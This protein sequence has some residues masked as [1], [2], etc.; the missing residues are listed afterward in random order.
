MNCRS[1]TKEAQ[2]VVFAYDASAQLQ[3]YDTDMVSLTG[4]TFTEAGSDDY[5][6]AVSEVVDVLPTD[7]EKVVKTVKINV[8]LGENN[9]NYLIKLINKPSETVTSYPI[10]AD[11]TLNSVV[12]KTDGRVYTAGN[13]NLVAL[14]RGSTVPF[15]TVGT[16][17]AGDSGKEGEYLEDIIFAATANAGDPSYGNMQTMYAIKENGSVWSWGKNTYYQLGDGS[18][19]DTNTPVRVGA[20]YLTMSKYLYSLKVSDTEQITPPTVDSFNVFNTGTGTSTSAALRWQTYDG[21]SDI[22]SVAADGKITAT[23]VGTTYVIVSIADDPLTTGLVKVE[24]RPN[25]TVVGA[26]SVAYPQIAAGTDF[27][28]AL[29]ADGTVWTWGN[30]IYGQLGNGVYNGTVVYPQKIDLSGVVKIAASGQFAVALKDNGEVWTWGRNNAGQLGNGTTDNSNVPVQV[31]KGDQNAG[32]DEK[33]YLENIVAIAAGGM[34]DSKG[35]AA[36]LEMSERELK[37]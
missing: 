5:Q 32:D 7:N 28:V 26:P 8:T 29:K 21:K 35:F 18:Q 22:V 15:G 30:N 13:T 34:D 19:T 36:A 3:Y 20:S 33:I 2:T 14:G 16:V 31:L 1:R 6:G 12:L 27:T 11:A 24:V 10:L 9:S 17:L 25:D 4:D 23:G 37:G